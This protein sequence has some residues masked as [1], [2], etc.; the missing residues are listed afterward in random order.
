MP[1]E[2][3]WIVLIVSSL[4]RCFY[5]WFSSLI[6]WGTFRPFNLIYIERSSGDTNYWHGGWKRWRLTV[7]QKMSWFTILPAREDLGCLWQLLSLR[8][9]ISIGDSLWWERLHRHHT[10]YHIIAGGSKSR[11]AKMRWPQSNASPTARL[12]IHRH[13]LFRTAKVVKNDAS[14]D[15]AQVKNLTRQFLF[16]VAVV[17]STKSSYLLSL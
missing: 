15:K 7:S 1:R 6:Q 3:C 5:I 10:R 9:L 17:L 2:I 14:R 12:T 4:L 16:L 8:S 11:I 13:W